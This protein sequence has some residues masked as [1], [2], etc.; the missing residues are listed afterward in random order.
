MFPETGSGRRLT[1]LLMTILGVLGLSSLFLIPDFSQA[2]TFHLL[3][4]LPYSIFAFAFSFMWA[5]LSEYHRDLTAM[6][7]TKDTAGKLIEFDRECSAR[8][9]VDLSTTQGLIEADWRNSQFDTRFTASRIKIEDDLLSRGLTRAKKDQAATQLFG[10]PISDDRLT[11]RHLAMLL[12]TLAPALMRPTWWIR[13]SFLKTMLLVSAF[14][15][16]LWSV[17]VYSTALLYH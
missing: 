15:A 10:A 16:V 11:R 1:G 3:R 5:V 12:E 4:P 9:P 17:L 8:G 6:A 7:Y 13:K 2:W 14:F